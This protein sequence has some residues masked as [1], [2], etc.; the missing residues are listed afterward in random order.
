MDYAG[1]ITAVTDILNYVVIDATSASPTDDP[2]FNAIIPSMI[3]YT[4]LRLQRDLDF[5]AT[6]V[7][8]TG[9]MVPNKRILTLPSV[10][11][12]AVSNLPVLLGKPVAA[13]SVITTTAGQ[14]LFNVYWPLH[15]MQQGQMVAFLVPIKVGGLTLGGDFIVIAVV[16]PNN[17]TLIASSNADTSDTATVVGNGLFIVTTQISPIVDGVRQPPMEPVTR[18]YLDFA[19]P[20]DQSPGAGV[21]P[22]QW[23]PNDQSAVLIGPAPDQA[24]GFEVVGTMRFPQLSA[25]NYQNFLTLNVPDLYVACAMIYATGYQRDFSAQSE[26]PKMAQSWE[27][28]YQML[29]KGAVVE[30][31]RKNYANMF[32]SPSN[33]STLQGT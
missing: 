29:L 9:T 15:N 21:V 26:D 17:I 3:N 5:I 20:S 19:W 30:E 8:A 24:Y 18:D 6:T 31:V 32:P 16:D 22:Y 11:L 13:G 23:C 7:T 2:A 4:E 1:F 12:P 28:Q 27:N 10:D 25:T 14:Q 33:P